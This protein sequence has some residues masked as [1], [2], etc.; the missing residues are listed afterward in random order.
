M[1]LE[2]FSNLFLSERRNTSLSNARQSQ[3][4]LNHLSSKSLGVFPTPASALDPI[5]KRKASILLAEAFIHLLYLADFLD[6]P[7]S[8]LCDYAMA[9][10]HKAGRG[11]HNQ[12]IVS[13]ASNGMKEAE[14]RKV[15]YED[16]AVDDPE[17][18][19]KA[20][21]R[22]RKWAMSRGMFEVVQGIVVLP[23]KTGHSA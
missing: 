8:D 12:L 19:R 11:G 20:Y 3:W 5:L 15:F 7:F 22:A 17:S 9:A 2:Q 16:C 4:A 6:C 14:L 1:T 23:S 10:E 18:R 13:L 21:F